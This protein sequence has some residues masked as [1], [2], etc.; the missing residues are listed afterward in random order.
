MKKHDNHRFPRS[1][2]DEPDADE[3][4]AVWKALEAADDDTPVAPERTNAAWEALSRKL[5]LRGDDT[6]RSGTDG[7]R[8][9][10]WDGHA[11]RRRARWSMRSAGLRIAAAVV[12]L[13][14]GVAIWQQIPVT[15]AALAGERLVA[16]LPDGS[17]VEL[18]AGSTLRFPRGFDVLPGVPQ[19]RRVVRL[20]GEAFFDVARSDRPFEVVAGAARV[21]VLGTRFNVRARSESGGAAPGVRVDVEEGRVRVAAEGSEAVAELGAGES[22]RVA[23]GIAELTPSPVALDRIAA[24]RSGGLTVSN[25]PLFS[26]VDELALRFGRNVS[27]ADSVDESVRVTAYYPLLTGVETVLR[28]LAT[29]QSLQVRRMSDGWELF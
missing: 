14:G 27:L 15:H 17:S 20:E 7:A 16:A 13:A 12:V 9:A 6:E 11:R 28:D 25:E 10:E 19:G 29:Q 21:T 5:A 24:W 23:Q 2:A 4:E 22:V 1:L 26:V 8:H 18:N 3:L